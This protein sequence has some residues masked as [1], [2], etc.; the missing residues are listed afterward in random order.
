MLSVDKGYRKRGI[1]ASPLVVLHTHLFIR[2]QRLHLSGILSVL[3]R[4]A[5]HRR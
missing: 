5:A 3:C 4:L 1:G 2:W